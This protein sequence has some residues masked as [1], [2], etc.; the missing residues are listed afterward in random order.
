[1]TTEKWGFAVYDWYTDKEVATFETDG[2]SGIFPVMEEAGYT[3]LYACEPLPVEQHH[4]LRYT[5]LP[6]HVSPYR[7]RHHW[8]APE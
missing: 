6:E 1:M 7:N 8:L 2:E 5:I 4:R 3:R